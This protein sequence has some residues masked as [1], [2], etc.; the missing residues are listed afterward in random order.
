MPYP[1]ITMTPWI[2]FWAK[3]LLLLLCDAHGYFLKKMGRV[4]LL[5]IV[6]KSS[7]IIMMLFNFWLYASIV[8]DVPRWLWL[9]FFPAYNTKKHTHMLTWK[10]YKYP[11]WSPAFQF[12]KGQGH[13]SSFKLNLETMLKYQH[14][15]GFLFHVIMDHGRKEPCS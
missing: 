14:H 2:V 1:L 5:W 9:S 7:W 12:C 11:Q 10:K 3:Q 13:E 8:F 15:M 6:A 4:L